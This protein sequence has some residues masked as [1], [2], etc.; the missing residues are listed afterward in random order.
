MKFSINPFKKKEPA[1]RDAYLE[2]SKYRNNLLTVKW[3]IKVKIDAFSIRAEK[4]M[5]QEEREI[6]AREAKI[7]SQIYE[8]VDKLDALLLKV[9]LRLD[10]YSDLNSVIE[11]FK[12]TNQA[13]SKLKPDL[14]ALSEAY[15][16]LFEQLSEAAQYFGTITIQGQSLQLFSGMG[17]ENILEEAIERSLEINNE[18]EELRS[19]LIKAAKEGEYAEMI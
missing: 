16:V 17:A 1:F 10:S 6:Y 18:Q 14:E 5:S 4:S 9:M 2:L 8:V 3:R 7:L 19:F 13:I 11:S 12:E 15:S